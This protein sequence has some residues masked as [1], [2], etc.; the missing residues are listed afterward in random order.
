MDSPSVRFLNSGFI[1]SLA[2]LRRPSETLI[3]AGGVSNAFGS[4]CLSMFGAGDAP[5]VAPSGGPERYRYADSPAGSP[6]RYVLLPT[7]DVNEP[8]GWLH[9]QVNALTVGENVV[10][11]TIEAGTGGIDYEF[12]RDLSPLVAR[13]RPALIALHRRFEA[14]R[15]LKHDV[16][17]CP[18]LRD[19][20]TLQ[21][22]TPAAGWDS[23]RM[24]IASM[25]N[26]L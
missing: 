1:Y 18:L 2:S 13:V 20:I 22:W 6:R 21:C 3:L 25:S 4:A 24:P 12:S 7:T 17:D 11:K 14:A 26:V 23:I 8:H 16:D 19:G 10:V 5:C 15:Q 9:N